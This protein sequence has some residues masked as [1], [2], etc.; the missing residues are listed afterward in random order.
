M[1]RNIRHTGLVVRDLERSIAFYEAL[2]LQVWKR[3]LETG[4]FIE[5][6]VGISEA[7]LEWAKMHSPDRHF[8]ELL[9]YHSD[10]DQSP[11]VPAPSNQLGCSHIAFT[12][13]DILATCKLIGQLGGSTVNPPAKSPSGNVLVAYCHDPDGILLEIVELLKNSL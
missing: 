4:H 8:I 12:V 6:V 3:A 9:Q 7:K 13:D 10:P 5:T 11:I 2:G 1:I